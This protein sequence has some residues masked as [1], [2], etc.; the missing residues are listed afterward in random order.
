MYLNFMPSNGSE[1]QR[2]TASARKRGTSSLLLLGP[3]FV[4]AVAYVDPGNVAANLTAGAEYGYLLV[5]VLV[6]ANLI[7]VLVQYLSSKLGLVSGQSLSGILGRRLGRRRRLAYWGQAEIVAIATDLAEV[8]GGAIALKILFDLPLLL[9]GVIVGIVSL[10]LLSIQS[11]RGQRPFEFVIIGFLAIIAIGF[12][13]GLVVGDVDWG[14]AAGG[15]LPRLEGTNSLVLAASMLGATVMPHAIYLH[16]ALSVDRHGGQPR[17]AIPRLL[18]ASRW[19]V[20]ASLVIAGSVNIAMLLLAAAALRGEGGT[21]TIEGAHAV[22]TAN[23]GEVVGL[24]FGIGLLASGLASSAVGSY[25]GASIM[26]GLLRV[27]IPIVWQR[28]VT[29]IPALIVLAIGADPTWALVVSQVVLSLGIP[30][31]MVPL[32]RLTANRAIMG[33]YANGRW[34]TTAAVIASALIIALNVALLVLLA[35]GIE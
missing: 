21:D 33:E 10:V 29:M 15:L 30:F 11:S 16:S 27:D 3:A 18:R 20:V 19:D 26:Q 6:A 5:W 24:F 1:T 14:Q 23:L 7:A 22:V 31:A 17:T 9:G 4:A 35:L 28:A 12:L 13:A 32:V 8:V 34:I 25:A 2:G